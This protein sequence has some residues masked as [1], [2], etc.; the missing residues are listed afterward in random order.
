MGNLTVTDEGNL[1][2]PTISP[3]DPNV[4]LHK[5]QNFTRKLIPPVNWLR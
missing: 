4:P 2:M 1:I 3:S 5:D